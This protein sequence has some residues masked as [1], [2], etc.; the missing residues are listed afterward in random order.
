MAVELTGGQ[1]L[2]LYKLYA[3]GQYK[4]ASVPVAEARAVVG[5]PQEIEYDESPEGTLPSHCGCI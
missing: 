4:D 3:G 5:V 1:N 2:S